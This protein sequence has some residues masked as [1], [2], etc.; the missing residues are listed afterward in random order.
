MLAD[1]VGINPQ[2]SAGMSNLNAFFLVRWDFNLYCISHLH[3]FCQYPCIK[4]FT[5][6]KKK[7]HVDWTFAHYF[8][9]YSNLGVGS[10]ENF[11]DSQG[12]EL[13]FLD[14]YEGLHHDN[15]PKMHDELILVDSVD[16]I[17][18]LTYI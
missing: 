1:G 13:Q 6:Q 8:D 7:N 5:K 3:T 11:Y 16:D 18:D 9:E 4:L 10:N 14:S 15:E 2:Q 17:F 12:C